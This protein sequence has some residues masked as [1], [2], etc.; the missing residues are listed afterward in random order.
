MTKVF[1]LMA[2]CTIS[3]VLATSSIA[4]AS[5][6]SPSSALIT[7]SIGWRVPSGAARCTSIA[8]RTHEFSCSTNNNRPCGVA[9]GSL[10]NHLRMLVDEAVQQL[11]SLNQIVQGGSARRVSIMMTALLQM[12]QG[13]YRSAVAGARSLIATNPNYAHPHWILTSSLGHL[14]RRDEAQVA[15]ARWIAI[16]PQQIR[17]IEMGLPCLDPQDT[18]RFLEGLRFAGWNG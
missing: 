12:L 4:P 3:V 9:G 11:V 8:S 1:H 15:L 2:A 6:R 10:C 17:L 13:D 16:A 5:R 14:G 18:D 7:A